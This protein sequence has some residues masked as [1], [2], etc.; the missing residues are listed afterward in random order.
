MLHKFSSSGRDKCGPKLA[1]DDLEGFDGWGGS[2]YEEHREV[3]FI[4]L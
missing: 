2:G 4:A 3:G 1:S